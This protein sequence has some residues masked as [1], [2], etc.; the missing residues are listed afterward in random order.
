MI[1]ARTTTLVRT[2]DLHAF[3]AALVALA[4]EGWPRAESRGWPLHARDRVVV[5]PTRAAAAQLTR[6]IEDRVLQGASPAH[7]ARALVLP[8]LITSGELV[9]HLAR[10]LPLDRRFLR[11]A[12]REILLAC[13]C[14]AVEHAG[15]QPPF[16]LRPGLVA[17]ILRFYDTLKRNQK[18][19]DTFERL[20]LGLL[21]PGAD[22]DRG[23]ARLVQQTRFLVAAFREFEQRCANVGVDEH[24]L[25]DRLLRTPVACP[26]R[27][28]VLAVTDRAF[29]PYGL[30]P[31]DWDLLARVPGLERL[32][33]VV[34]DTMLAGALHERIHHLLPDIEERRI[35][36]GAKTSPILM[37]S[38]SS[39]LHI[40][41]DR[42]EEVA[43]FVRRVK[44]GER[45]VALDRIA[46]VVQRPLP[47]VYIAQE[48]FR[49]GGIP[50]QMTDALPLAAEPFAAAFDLVCSC[51]AA[52]FARRPSI[53]LLRSPHF[54][55]ESLMRARKGP[56]IRALDRAL[57][58][59]AYLGGIETL[60]LLITSWRESGAARAQIA[61][62]L[63]AGE[64][65]LAIARNLQPLRTPQPAALHLSLLQ[66]F[67]I[68]HERLPGPD[69]PLR[70]RQLRARGAVLGIIDSLRDAYAR[71]DDRPVAFDDVAALVRRWIEDHTFAPRVGDS[72]VHVLDA[73]SA[74]F[75]DFDVVQI[76][77][78]VDGEWPERPRRSIFYSTG[79]LRE[80][81]W[82]AE[83]E[84]QDGARAGFRDLLR[85]PAE[86]LLVSAFTLE[87]DAMVAPSTFVDEIGSARL[88]QQQAEPPVTRVFE[89]EALGLQPTV[90]SV[91][92]EPV[93]AWTELRVELAAADEARRRGTTLPFALPA[94]SVGALERY[95]DCP[96]RFFASEVLRLEEA[97]ED[98]S[99]MTPRARGRF[100]HEV[101]QRFFA[102]WDQR[103]CGPITSDRIE[104][105]RQLFAEVAEP[106]LT[107]L[108]EADAALERT[109]LFGSAISVG[110]VDIVLGF[111]VARPADVQERWLE[112]RLDGAFSLRLST[113]LT[114]G[115]SEAGSAKATADKRFRLKGVAD[116]VDLLDGRRLRVIDYKTGSAPNP[117]RALQVRIYALCAQELL[118]DGGDHWTIDQAAYIAFGARRPVVDVVNGRRLENAEVLA[119]ARGRVTDIL[120]AISRGEFPVRPH[121]P[122]MCGYC[123]YPAV[124]RKDYVGEDEP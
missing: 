89:Y 98:E 17:E 120:D 69:D 82:P 20:A 117:K 41:R 12:E 123:S 72:G 122:I 49:A 42:E 25:R 36:E 13:A 59:A 70:Q 27:H 62:A 23:A 100:M 106:M 102:A 107:S 74:P 95:Q 61:D 3:R 16:R 52:D 73:A 118:N 113:A 77:G 38:S 87:A 96:F 22:V 1:T 66:D 34:T 53:A 48:I 15:V 33:L 84:H 114:A 99:V 119:D 80:L 103:A 124:C 11:D 54:G 116:R 83:S 18:E 55:F 32:D 5:V 28:V 51:V 14:R 10:R 9:V 68:D 40:A 7:G 86:R 76:A 31:A 60:E 78:L 24:G 44:C 88:M 45:D 63:S 35:E 109:R 57:N 65:L 81:G 115:P 30:A 71:F 64:T 39:A 94:F 93:R 46:L 108:P 29:D 26:I 75:G 112:R 43:G 92:P 50:C 79:V 58:E 56:S 47:Y 104:V 101:L 105:A 90:F 85:L 8:D 110:L 4:C 97:E 37:T 6:A 2:A 67:L 121:D 21:E 91:L 111:E 19:V